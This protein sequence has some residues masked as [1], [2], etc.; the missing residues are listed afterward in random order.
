MDCDMV[1]DTNRY[2]IPNILSHDQC[3][4]ECN[5][6]DGRELFS[7]I[8]WFYSTYLW[9]WYLQSLIQ[10]MNVSCGMKWRTQNLWGRKVILNSAGPGSPTT[11]PAASWR[12]L[13]G[14]VSVGITN[15]HHGVCVLQIFSIQIFL[16]VKEGNRQSLLMIQIIWCLIMKSEYF[17]GIIEHIVN[18]AAIGLT[19][20]Q[21]TI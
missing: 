10:K 3:Y 1:L 13:P 20:N 4:L 5:N 8:P 21:I 9:P 6:G 15:L 11:Q 18:L 19:G 12:D 16:K 17:L 2:R 14:A 7:H